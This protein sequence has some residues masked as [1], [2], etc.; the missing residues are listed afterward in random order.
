MFEIW[1]NKKVSKHLK[2]RQLKENEK[3]T[4]KNKTKT[5]FKKM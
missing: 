2:N 3:T 5:I 4:I 1:E